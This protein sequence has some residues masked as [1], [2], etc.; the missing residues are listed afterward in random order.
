MP[1]IA[2]TFLTQPVIRFSRWETTA[3]V[4]RAI[5][6]IFR[7]LPPLLPLGLPL[8]KSRSLGST[9]FLVGGPCGIFWGQYSSAVGT[10]FIKHS[11]TLS[12]PVLFVAYPAGFLFRRGCC[13]GPM[14][15]PFTYYSYFLL[16]EVLP[17]TVL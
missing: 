9:E 5:P 4:F 13:S 8:G 15:C 17:L 12:S 2:L 7:L 14:K 6:D 11:S 16:G 3:F 1:R 10:V